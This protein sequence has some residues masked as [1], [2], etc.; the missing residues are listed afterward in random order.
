MKH[1]NLSFLYAFCREKYY[2]FSWDYLWVLDY[3]IVQR[4]KKKWIY[5]NLLWCS[6]KKYNE[7]IF[8]YVKAFISDKSVIFSNI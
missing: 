3:F 6:S 4:L 2:Q 1:K 8:L 5:D 7:D